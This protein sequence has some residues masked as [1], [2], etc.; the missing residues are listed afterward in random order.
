MSE[1]DFTSVGFYNALNE[2]KLLGSKC[3][4]C[5]KVHFPPREICV[6]CLSSDLEPIE[7]S[8][9]GT[10]EAYTVVY[11]ATTEMIEAGY[12]RDNP[13]CAGIVRLEEGPAI[14]AQILGVDV[15]APESI[16][17]GIPVQATFVERG[18]DDNKKTYLGF[19]P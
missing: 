17:I 3:M 19:Q 7:F 1:Y 9:K 4:K 10:L 12:G 16:K 2:K 8:G 15:S 5:G 13:H 14:S 11:I 18:S 6:K